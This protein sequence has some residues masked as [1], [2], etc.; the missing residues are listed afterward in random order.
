MAYGQYLT[1]WQSLY[2]STSVLPVKST[3]GTN[4]SCALCHDTTT[5][6]NIG[7][8]AYGD[9][10]AGQPH[11]RTNTAQDQT[12]FKNIESRNSDNDPTGSTNIQEINANAQPGWTP[13]PNNTIYD[14]GSGGLGTV[15]IL[16]GATG[17]DQCINQNPPTFTA[18]PNSVGLDPAGSA[19]LPAV[20]NAGLNQAADHVGIMVQLDGSG[21]SDPEKQ[22]IT[23]S[24][25]FVLPLPSGSHATLTGPTTV[26][27][28][29]VPD[30]PGTYVVQLIVTD[31]LGAPSQ[32]AN[33]TIGVQQNLPP[34]ASIATPPP[35][36]VGSAVQLNGSGSSDPERQ[37]ITY[38]WSFVLPLPSSSQ[39]T[40]T[41]PTTVTPTFVP[42]VV[43][44]YRVQLI[45]NDGTQNSLPA[46][47][48]ITPNGVPTGK[49]VV[50]PSSPGVGMLVTLDGSGSSDPNLDPL[51]YKWTLVSVPTGSTLTTLTNPTAVNPT[52][53]PD[54]AGS[55]VVRL[56]VNDGKVDSTPA[57]VTIGVLV[58]LPPVAN[59]G[60]AQT[61]IL[62]N[63]VQLDGSASKD[64]EGLSLTYSW[65]FVSVPPGSGLMTLTN[66][67]A[68]NPTFT[69]D[70]VGSYVAG[71]VVN[72]GVFKS[73][74]TL[75][76]NV[77]ITVQPLTDNTP[78]ALSLPAN[79]T[80]STTNSSGMAITYTATANDAVDGVVPV[81]C[82]PA[83][84]ATFPVGTTT[85]SCSATDKASNKASG[86]FTVTVQTTTTPPPT[87]ADLRISSFSASE[88]VHVGDQVRLRLSVRNAGTANGSAPA[89]LVGM[90]SGVQVYNQTITVSAVGRTA[91][92]FSFPSYTPTA[93]GYIRWTVTVA[94][95]TPSSRTDT[96]QVEGGGTSTHHED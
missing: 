22:P 47:V 51:T 75:N 95:Q 14:I 77:T 1:A 81:S 65:S 61:V 87:G 40:L 7:L 80:Q 24:W 70:V 9:A 71:L 18:Y 35:A 74:Q 38:S 12:A 94:D 93:R 13:G 2:G 23:Y 67:T 84:G 96:T 36:T 69:P 19:N 90:Q 26:N 49:I 44:T 56:V 30:V 5:G 11:S 63:T 58:N 50:T 25:S 89:T 41:G 60:P 83:S 64:P 76:S 82:L 33:V 57:T 66:P 29:F 88:E 39:A 85:V 42:D 73:Q 48:D 92:S 16:C 43:G 52:F 21:S 17:A 32:P 4:A 62:G 37:P 46:I 15:A 28:S 45:V 55:Y 72:D 10:F 59:A 34:V 53:T 3:S 91:S 54:V 20:A 79:I 68:V 27:P 6:P 8:N 31:N 78:P 86:T